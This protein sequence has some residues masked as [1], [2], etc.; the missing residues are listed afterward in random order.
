MSAEAGYLENQ[1]TKLMLPA[2]FAP[3]K[4]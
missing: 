2:S 1:T 4:R 3:I